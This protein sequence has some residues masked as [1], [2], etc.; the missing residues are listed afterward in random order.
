M[1]CLRLAVETWGDGAE[2]HKGWVFAAAL[3]GSAFLDHPVQPCPHIQTP[4]DQHPPAGTF[5]PLQ[6][7][8][9]CKAERGRKQRLWWQPQALRIHL[10]LEPCRAGSKN[11]FSMAIGSLLEGCWGSCPFCPLHWG[12][13]ISPTPAPLCFEVGPLLP[14]EEVRPARLLFVLSLPSPRLHERALQCPTHPC[15]PFV[16]AQSLHNQAAS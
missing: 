4:G 9:L 5:T 7:H 1:L 12:P 11:A 10:G 13:T 2:T 16:V 6:P 3:S 8:S 14:R 15:L